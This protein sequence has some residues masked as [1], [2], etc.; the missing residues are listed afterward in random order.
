[1]GDT[2]IEPEANS[3]EIA[4]LK[5]EKN[6]DLE[7]F[8]KNDTKV[9]HKTPE[10]LNK[11]R[12]ASDTT[13]NSGSSSTEKVKKLTPKQLARKAEF[14]RKRLEKERL[15]EEARLEKEAAK[16]AARVKKEA[17]KEE[18]RLKKEKEKNEKERQKKEKAEEKERLKKKKEEQKENERRQKEEKEKKKQAEKQAEKDEKERQER[19]KAEKAEKAKK[20]FANFFMKK[21]VKTTNTATPKIIPSNGLNQFR[22]KDDMKLAPIHRATHIK[23]NELDQLETKINIGLEK[24]SLY[25]SIL[26]KSSFKPQSM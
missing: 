18:E 13:P 17:E 26:Q 11:K 23:K 24:D 16:E 4:N 12:K 20:S 14:D 6:D 21:D 8:E 22:V 2:K 25:I 7:S 19:A 9:V 10:N 15:K 5:S 1:M 3:D